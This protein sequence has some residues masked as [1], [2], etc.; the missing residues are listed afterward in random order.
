M[1]K[2][3]NN[4]SIIFYVD[5]DSLR[6]IWT[7]TALRNIHCSQ[8]AAIICSSES[9]WWGHEKLSLTLLLSLL[10]TLITNKVLLYGLGGQ[11]KMRG[12]LNYT[13][14]MA[15]PDSHLNIPYLLFQWGSLLPII[16]DR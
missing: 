5:S 9:F 14:A 2:K 8:I 11:L 7:S 12:N 1:K 13:I 15:R 3:I 6:K 4:G 10:L 16:G